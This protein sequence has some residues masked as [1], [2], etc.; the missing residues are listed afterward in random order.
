MGKRTK[1]PKASRPSDGAMKLHVPADLVERAHEIRAASPEVEDLRPDVA[2]ILL[3]ALRR[4]LASKALA[5]E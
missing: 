5:R 3:A 1:E 2:T 4:G